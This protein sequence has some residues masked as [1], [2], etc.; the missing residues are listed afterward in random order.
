[1]LARRTLGHTLQ[2]PILKVMVVEASLLGM[3]TGS[4][5]KSHTLLTNAVSKVISES[6]PHRIPSQE[7]A[8]L[9]LA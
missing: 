4:R 1:M 5:V 6:T 8:V 9:L 2:S 3:R 7:S